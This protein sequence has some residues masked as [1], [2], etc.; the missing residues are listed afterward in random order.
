MPRKPEHFR[1]PTSP[2]STV[3]TATALLRLAVEP[4]STQSSLDAAGLEVAY[5][6]LL[7]RL[8]LQ[9]ILDRFL[10]PNVQRA[11]GFIH[12]W[13]LSATASKPP[14]DWRRGVGW[15]LVRSSMM[16]LGV[17]AVISRG[18]PAQQL[19]CDRC[20]RRPG[21]TRDPARRSAPDIWRP[22][23]RAADHAPLQSSPPGTLQRSA[24]YPGRRFQC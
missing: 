1:F 15:S 18:Y 21:G 4:R 5:Q 9:V 6:D 24:A 22:N 14:T 2:Y 19:L 8:G 17:L 12:C 16:R 11:A 23:C 3:G 10:R 13:I 20:A 7:D